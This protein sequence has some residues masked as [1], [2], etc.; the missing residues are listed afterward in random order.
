MPSKTPARRA[1]PENPSDEPS[2]D[3]SELDGASHSAKELSPWE[4]ALVEE[5]LERG[6]KAREENPERYAFMVKVI[7]QDQEDGLL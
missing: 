3:C 4:Q 7:Q 1:V 6:K 5:I 2:P